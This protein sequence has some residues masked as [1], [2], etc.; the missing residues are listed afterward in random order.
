MKYLLS[1]MDKNN[2]QMNKQYF[3]GQS[4]DEESYTTGF[5]VSFT[6]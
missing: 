2:L 6:I 5:S 1:V 3:K 4:L